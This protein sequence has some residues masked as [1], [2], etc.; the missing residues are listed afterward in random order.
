M[1]KRGKINPNNLLVI[2]CIIGVILYIVF[3]I[4][5]FLSSIIDF[6]SYFEY[7]KYFVWPVLI[8][9]TVLTYNDAI[10]IEAGSKSN[11]E[12]TF[13]TETWSPLTWALI[14]LILYPFT[15]PYYIHKREK[16]WRLN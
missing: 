7:N 9:G 12:K 2:F 11:K 15:L 1:K 14:V 8:I 16:I 3:F 13:N 6:P 4:K 5:Y 10:K